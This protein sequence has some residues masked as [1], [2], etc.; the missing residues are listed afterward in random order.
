MKQ[1]IYVV[2]AM[3]CCT[4]FSACKTTRLLTASFESD[5]IGSSPNKTLPGDP[6]GDEIGFNSII[7]PQLK[8]QS[9]TISGSKALFYTNVATDPITASARWIS[10]KGAPTDLSKTV[11]FMY[12]AQNINPAQDVTVDLT[13]GYSAA[14][15]RLRIQPD[16]TVSI[17]TD[18]T[19]LNYEDIGNV[20]TQ[21]HTVIFTTSLVTKKYNVTIFRQSGPAITVENK[22]F[23]QQNATLFKNP[24]R[25]TISFTHSGTASSHTYAIGIVSIS[26]EKPKNMP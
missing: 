18:N 24:A 22:P 1:I 12:A 26:K 6:S 13:D 3:A 4:M 25:P 17:A 2:I 23:M 20:G 7:I 10:F 15:A 11:W 16:G 19:Y 14:I 8:V 9:S 21:V 5:A